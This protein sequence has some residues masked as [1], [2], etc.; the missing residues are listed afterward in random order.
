LPS[1]NNADIFVAGHGADGFILYRGQS[2]QPI[3]LHP[4]SIADAGLIVASTF[5]P[6]L[7]SPADLSV[8][9]PAE[10]E[11]LW[12]PVPGASGYQVTVATDDTFASGVT[13]EEITVPDGNT[14]NV[15]P[16]VT[17][18]MVDTAYYWRVQ[19]MDKAA[20]LSA[21]SLFRQFSVGNGQSNMPPLALIVSPIDGAVLP[22]A[23]GSGVS[24]QG[25]F[26]DDEDVELPAN[27]LQWSL[28]N[29]DFA[30][31]ELWTGEGHYPFIPGPS[32]GEVGLYRITLVVTDSQGATGTVSHFVTVE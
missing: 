8:W 15:R 5:V 26:T 27:A 32:F 30:G 19:A 12:N 17:R 24:C 29:A 20:L 23:L 11:L 31:E 18:L 4:G 13:V 1:N 6:T 2:A 21:P 3:F 25:S 10:L 14:T 28:V 9:A 22:D 7:N 16:D